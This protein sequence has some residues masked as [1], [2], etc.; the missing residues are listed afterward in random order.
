MPRGWKSS[1]FTI[2]NSNMGLTAMSDK[3]FDILFSILTVPEVEF[4]APMAEKLIEKGHSI[5]FILFHEAGA[6][7]LSE[8]KIPFFNMHRL[9]AEIP[10]RALSDAEVEALRTEFAIENLRHLFIHEKLGYNRK[11]E[12]A[13]TQKVLH[14]LQILDTIFSENDVK[15]VIQELG[16]FGANQCVYY[17]ARKNNVDHVFYE[18]SAFSRRIVFNLNSYYSNIP[19]RVMESRYDG[20]T[21][22]AVEKYWEG[23]LAEKP[24]VIPFKDKQS[25]ADMTLKKIF[26]KENARRLRRKLVHK[27]LENKREEYDEIG[28][29]IRANCLKLAR[30]MLL[31]SHYRDPDFEE[32]YIYFPFHVPHDVQLTSRSRLFYFQEGFVEYL[33]RIVPYGYKLYM[34]EHPASIGGHPYGVMKEILKRHNNVVL[35]HPRINSYDLVKHAS[36][37]IVVN[38]KVGFEAIMQGKRVVV[39]GDAFY[40]GKGV[41]FDSDHPGEVESVIAGALRAEA[42]S[43][44]KV[45]EFLCKVHQWSYPCELFLMEKENIEQSYQSFYGYLR[46]ERFQR[47]RVT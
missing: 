39:V 46:S 25:F 19:A 24:V 33:C 5:G 9:R 18:P 8:M 2:P 21:K 20:E 6:E 3:R 44:E 38:S 10:C 36:L 17:A 41:T 32:K 45:M 37:V 11:N 31:N 13:L 1:G 34:K 28:W 35:I 15:C 7:K 43:R 22:R 16:G 42:P 27:Y 26:N 4:L 47:L 23:Y 14:Y 30:R 12:R 29:V 40:K